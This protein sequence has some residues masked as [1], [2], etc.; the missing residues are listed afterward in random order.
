MLSAILGAYFDNPG[1]VF[2]SINNLFCQLGLCLLFYFNHFNIT[3]YL[4]SMPYWQPPYCV[5]KL[6][7][8]KVKSAHEPIVAH[9]TG[10]YPDFYSMK[11]LGVFLLPPGWDASPSQSYPPTL[12]LPIPIYSPW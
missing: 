5:V 12:T 6:Y 4:V 3:F 10:A 9:Q 8:L 11:Q 2:S 7:N 1:P